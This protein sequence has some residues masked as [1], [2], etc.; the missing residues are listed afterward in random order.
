MTTNS[1]VRIVIE[2]M[3]A[4]IA[5]EIMAICATIPVVKY[6]AFDKVKL[7][8]ADFLETEIPA[9]QLIDVNLTSVHEMSR[10]KNNWQI[11]LELL[12]KSDESVTVSQSDL[13]N[14]EYEVKR[15]LWANPGLPGVS[16]GAGGKVIQMNFI[17]SQTD[18]HLLEPYYFSRLDFEVV[19]YES[20]V[21]DC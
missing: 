6:V 3:K 2:S 9:I 21:T 4:K 13:W 18:L 12:M 1:Q 10:S 17:G 5:R 8:A 20:L 14:L 11:A 19:Y 15:K 7:L 16:A